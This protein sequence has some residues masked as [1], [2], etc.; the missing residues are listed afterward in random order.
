MSLACQCCFKP[1]GGVG[2]DARLPA[3]LPCMC[4]FCKGCL[5]EEEAKVQQQKEQPSGDDY[6]PTPCMNCKMLC[7][8]PVEDLLLDVA[9]MKAVSAGTAPS[10]TPPPCDRCEEDEENQ[11]TRFCKDV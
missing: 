9:T 5:L 3:I 10:A 4:R 6:K 1:Y 8:K 2:E 7:T 11:A